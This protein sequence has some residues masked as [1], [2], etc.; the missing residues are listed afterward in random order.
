MTIVTR[1]PAVSLLQEVTVSPFS[2]V[3]LQDCFAQAVGTAHSQTLPW[4]LPGLGSVWSLC[5]IPCQGE[6]ALEKLSVSP[7]RCQAAHRGGQAVLSRA[8]SQEKSRPDSGRAVLEW[9]HA[10]QAHEDRH[11]LCGSD[12]GVGVGVTGGGAVQTPPCGGDLAAAQVLR[13]SSGC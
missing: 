3:S 5:W 7:A 6:F 1:L 4:P 8:R 12:S 10:G 13:S 9:T 11:I 2:K